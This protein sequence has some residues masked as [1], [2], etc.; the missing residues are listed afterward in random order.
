MQF[1]CLPGGEVQFQQLQH[2]HE[3]VTMSFHV[4]GITRVRVYIH[5]FTPNKQELRMK[6][7]T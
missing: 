1:S 6:Q 2:N 3:L 4:N 5:N 7:A